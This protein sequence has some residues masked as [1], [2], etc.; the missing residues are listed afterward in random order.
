MGWSLVTGRG[1]GE[2]RRMQVQSHRRWL[3]PHWKLSVMGTESQGRREVRVW[4]PGS[5]TGLLC[6]IGEAT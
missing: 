4:P 1:E 3:R 6:D 5:I 2:S